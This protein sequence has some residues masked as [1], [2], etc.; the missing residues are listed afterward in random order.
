L[1][2]VVVVAEAM[3][4]ATLE[5]LLMTMPTTAPQPSAAAHRTSTGQIIQIEI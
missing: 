1:T 5:F 2:L 4:L 3:L